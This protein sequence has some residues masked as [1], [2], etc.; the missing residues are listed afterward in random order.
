MGSGAF[1]VQACR[2]LA[3]RLLEAWA[4]AGTG[5]RHLPIDPTERMIEARRIVAERCL[6]GVD[7]N[8]MAAELAKLSLWLVTMSR[9]R[10]FGYLDHA[11]RAGDSL[12]GVTDVNQVIYFHL[13]P[14]V[15]KK[16]HGGIFNLSEEIRIALGKALDARGKIRD[17]Q[18]LDITDIQEMQLLGSRAAE[19][20]EIARLV[21]DAVVGA[22]L[23]GGAVEDSRLAERYSRL[24][25]ILG[26]NMSSSESLSEIVQADLND[27]LPSGESD[28]RPLHWPLEFPEAFSGDDPGFD[29]IVGNPPFKGGQKITGDLGGSSP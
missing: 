7:R 15:G 25:H 17:H 18:T 1:L 27:D 26:A 14:A 20:T 2:Y 8:S 28:R 24:G 29:A 16:L 13:N 6:Y 19:Y 21:A 9:H 23:A 10:P 12:L 11:L 5:G 3:E 22:T 4:K